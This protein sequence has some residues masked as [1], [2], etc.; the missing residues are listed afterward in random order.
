MNR[1][2]ALAIVKEYIKNPGLI[3]HMIS[4][5]AV[6]RFYAK[7]LSENVDQ[8]GITGLLHDFDW[9]I[10]PTAELHPSAGSEILSHHGVR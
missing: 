5:E 10:H 2:D 3:N 4:V 6:M 7:Q 8:W 9:E 1:A